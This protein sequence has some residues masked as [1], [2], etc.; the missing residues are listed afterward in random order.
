M[1]EAKRISIE[2]ARR[3]VQGGEALFV[4]AYDSE[5]MCGGIRLEKAMTMGEFNSRLSEIPKE[6]EL[7]FY[8]Q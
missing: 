2:E 7:I 8:C 3:K 4:C 6:K 1:S 5:E